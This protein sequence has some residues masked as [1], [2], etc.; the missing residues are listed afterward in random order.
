MADDNDRPRPLLMRDPIIRRLLDALG[1]D[2][3]LLSGVDIRMRHN[4]AVSVTVH[5][6]VDEGEA[7]EAATYAKEHLLCT[8]AIAI[9]T[10]EPI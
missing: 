10:D 4:E 7:D 2:G 9:V 8:R 1:V 3:V 6:F 5:R